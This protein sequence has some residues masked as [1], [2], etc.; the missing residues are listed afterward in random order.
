VT[1]QEIQ[2]VLENHRLWLDDSGGAKA[3]FSNA[4]LSGADLSGARLRDVCLI[5]A[6]LRNANL[7]GAN[8]RGAN[9]RNADLRDADLRGARLAG[10]DLRGANLNGADLREVIL[11]YSVLPLW[12][13]GLDWK[14]DRD[15][16]AQL[17]Y[18]ACSMD[19]DDPDFIKARNSVLDFAN[20]FRSARSC[21]ILYE[22][23]LTE[24]KDC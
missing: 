5:E 23:S 13:G 3:D 20:R 4:D 7:R 19:C 2:E 18:H 14:I 17:F 9:L 24:Q 12:Y 21:G 15:T 16:A 6:D 10:A 22:R 11:D 8:L 1:Q